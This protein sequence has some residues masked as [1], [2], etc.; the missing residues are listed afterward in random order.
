M[1]YY[2]IA[3]LDAKGCNYNFIISGRGP[4]K[5]TA[6][7]NKLIDDFFDDGSTFVRIARYDWETIRVNMEGW[8]NGVNYRHLQDRLQTDEFRIAFEQR[9]WRLY[10]DAKHFRVMG[11]LVTLNNQD[12][13][14]SVSFDDCTNIVYEEFAMLS[15]RDYMVGE[16]AAYLSAVSTIVRSRQNV[17]AWFI[18]N[19]LDKHNPF[20]D[21]FGI[22]IDRIGLQPGDIRTFRC[23]GFDGLGATVAVEFAEMSYEDISE[24]SPLMRIAGN[25]TATTGFYQLAD[26]VAQYDKRCSYVPPTGWRRAMGSARGIYL[27][28]DSFAEVDVSRYPVVEGSHVMRLRKATPDSEPWRG[29]W[30]NTSGIEMP[31]YTIEPKDGVKVDRHLDVVNPRVMY[32]DAKS[33]KAYQ[34]FD[35]ACVHAYETDEMRFQWENFVDMYGYERQ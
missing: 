20:F 8:F 18:G 14:K 35:A 30:V 24:I 23:R 10:T 26:S 1:R 7:V 25:D 31:T 3:P 34:V 33:F 29:R 13:Y 21:L 32:A 17:R 6:M 28:G 16:V 27:G 22:D 15:Q 9:Q 12:T 4:G 2:D 5:S 11:S 19:T